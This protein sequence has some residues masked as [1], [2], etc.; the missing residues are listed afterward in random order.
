MARADLHCHS[1]F[2]NHP[3]EWFLKRLG[4][5]ESYTAPEF[6]YAS[7]KARGMRF[8]TVS[9]HNRIEASLELVEKY[10]DEAFTGVESMVYF[11]D[12]R[13]K[14][15]ILLWGLTPAQFDEVERAIAFQEREPE[16][17]ARMRRSARDR[18][19]AD[20]DWERILTGLL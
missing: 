10:P 8:V 9:D 5:A 17:Y 16:R 11:P 18:V 15:H 1:K 4:S 13:A 3:S 12:N 20:R 7:A 2:S 19:I 6:V 14:V